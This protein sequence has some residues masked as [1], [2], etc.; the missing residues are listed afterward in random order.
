LYQA[1][2]GLAGTSSL[3]SLTEWIDYVEVKNDFSQFHISA[4]ELMPDS[5]YNIVNIPNVNALNGDILGID[6]ILSGEYLLRLFGIA[7]GAQGISGRVLDFN[8]TIKA[9]SIFGYAKLADV[10]GLRDTT[11]LKIDST[12]LRLT[13]IE[14]DT[15]H[16]QIAWDSVAIFDGRL[17]ALEADSANW[18]HWED[19]IANIATKYDLDTLSVSV[20]DSMDL[21]LRKSGDTTM[22]LTVNGTDKIIFQGTWAGHYTDASISNIGNILSI[23]NDRGGGVSTGIGLSTNID[24]NV[25]GAVAMSVNSTSVGITGT[26]SVGSI[27][28]ATTDIDRFLKDSAGI[29]KYRTGAE[30]LSDI[31]GQEAGSYVPTTRNITING[32]AY[33][34]SADRSWTVSPMV[35]PSAGIP[36]STGS[37]WGTSITDNSVNWDIAYGWGNHALAGY[38]TSANNVPL[39]PNVVNDLTLSTQYSQTYRQP[40]NQFQAM[41]AGEYNPHA[42]L[43]IGEYYYVL[44]RST[45]AKLFKYPVEDITSSTSLTFPNDG[46]NKSPDQMLYIGG[47]IYIAMSNS[48]KLRVKQINPADFSD[49]TTVIS[50]NSPSFISGVPMLSDGTYLYIASNSA[51]GMSYADSLYK[52]QIS[53]WS[54]VAKIKITGSSTDYPHALATDGEK[55]FL[56]TTAATANLNRVY[57]VDVATFSLDANSIITYAPMS[58]EM[59]VTGDKLYIGKEDA[60]GYILVIDK[61]VSPMTK[62]SINTGIVAA[63]YGIFFDGKDI[64]ATMAGTPGGLAKI[65]PYTGWVSY[66][67]F[68]SGYNNTNEVSFE[69]GRMFVTFYANPFSVARITLPKMTPTAVG[70]GVTAVTATAPLSSSGGATPDIS[71]SGTINV[72][73]GGTNL[74]YIAAGSVLAAN[75]TDTYSAVTSTSG[76]KVLTNTAGTISWETQTSVLSATVSLS[77]AQIKAL[78]TTP[79]TVVSAPGSG[80]A[81]QVISA[82]VFFDYTAPVYDDNYAFELL[83]NGAGYSQFVCLSLLDSSSDTFRMFDPSTYSLTSGSTQLLE[84]QPLNIKVMGSTNPSSGNSTAK[85][86]VTYRII[87]L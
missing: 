25:N 71:L 64:W 11:N 4:F 13:S 12:K 48:G 66:M 20:N 61:S 40:V 41:A 62:D 33:D 8:G 80:Y 18:L 14:D 16:Y 52:Y 45:P 57:V 17:N 43:I 46:L 28:H 32:M 27:P 29:I 86:Y 38:L 35:Y 50:Y 69:G 42:S 22:G 85:I 84:N 51:A 37:A 47:K 15:A 82:S 53:D 54:Q 87:T 2:T 83:I 39:S 9:D 63:C 67:T 19:T 36:M 55:I 79:I 68:P 59:V 10:E 70:G 21:Y 26:L 78:A 31:G 58:D 65:D 73:H 7:D 23:D 5:R 6:F 34:L 74:N 3:S 44:T 76:T 30:L 72:L 56:T 60:T 81:I 24:F 77:S 49:T 75:S 1:L